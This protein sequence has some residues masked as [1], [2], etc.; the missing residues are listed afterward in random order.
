MELILKV[1]QQARQV[2]IAFALPMSEEAQQQGIELV[3]PEPEPE[4]EAEYVSR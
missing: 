2:R 1:R 3:D 4:T